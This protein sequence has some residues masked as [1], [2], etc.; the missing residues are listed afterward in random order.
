MKSYVICVKYGG[1]VR[2]FGLC[3]N[4]AVAELTSMLSTV[5]DLETGIVGLVTP[6]GLT[7]ADDNLLDVH[8]GYRMSVVSQQTGCTVGLSAVAR[9]LAVIEGA[10]CELLLDCNITAKMPSTSVHSATGTVPI[11]FK[12]TR[13]PIPDPLNVSTCT[14]TSVAAGTSASAP[15]TIVPLALNLY[16]TPAEL[17]RRGLISVSQQTELEDLIRAKDARVFHYHCEHRDLGTLAVSLHHLPH[18]TGANY[19]GLISLHRCYRRKR[20]YLLLK[21]LLHPCRNSSAWSIP[22]T[23]T[24]NM[25]PAATTVTTATTATTSIIAMAVR[26]ATA[27]RTAASSQRGRL[28]TSLRR[29]T[30][31]LS[32]TRY[33]FPPLAHLLTGSNVRVLTLFSSLRTVGS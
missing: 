20:S 24:Q 6:V 3:D 5:F 25:T 18:F 15:D 31:P 1:E 33:P 4:M 8:C 7:C 32:L 9:N 21:E 12:A 11:A 19:V 17:S 27:A 16:D 30:S 29:T 26:T 14:S 13:I 2:S 10:V 28:K 23:V 22:Q